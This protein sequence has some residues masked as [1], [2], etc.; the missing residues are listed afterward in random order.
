M[1]SSTYTR[2]AIASLLGFL[3][4]G[5]AFAQP[6]LLII[7]DDC[8]PVSEL[9]ATGAFSVVDSF[10]HASGTPTLAQLQGYDAVLAFSNSAP[11]DPA[12]LGDVL[13]DYVDGGGCLTMTTYAFSDDWSFEGRIMTDGYSPFEKTP[14]GGY[15]TPDGDLVPVAPADP[16]FAGVDVNA[17]VY[18]SNDNMA[19]GTLDAGATLLATDGSGINMVARAA[20]RPITGFNV[21]A[22]DSECGVNNAEFFRMLANSLTSCAG[23]GRTPLAIPSASHSGLATLAALLALAAVVALRLRR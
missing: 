22:V 2:C 9:Q 12:A 6:S 10:D 5:A 4:A 20:N 7:T 21:W 18:Q 15:S 3:V 11:A 19:D 8:P 13:A 17:L 14:S 1:N 23:T 16:I